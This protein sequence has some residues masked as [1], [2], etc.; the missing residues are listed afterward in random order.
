MDFN[1][2]V[3]FAILPFDSFFCLRCTLSKERKPRYIVAKYD[4]AVC[5]WVYTAFHIHSI[6]ADMGWP[7]KGSLQAGS[8]TWLGVISTIDSMS[9]RAYGFTIVEL[10]IVV[11]VVAILAAISIVAYTGIQNR[12]SDSALQ[13]DLRNIGSKLAEYHAIHGHYPT[14]NA[15]TISGLEPI[16]I[17]EQAYD[18]SVNNLYVCLG[19]NASSGNPMA[20]AVA[21]SRSGKAFS[22][23]STSGVA[24]Y[25]SGYTSSHTTMCSRLGL[26]SG[27]DYALGRNAAESGWRA[28]I[29]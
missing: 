15:T 27:H 26:A 10:L 8:L 11:V 24:E 20:A 25:T 28:W 21:L 5:G 7:V 18:L 2:W 14:A 16:P 1:E 3:L 6:I 4:R 17:T 19:T 12:A 22:Y 23:R 13:S 9:K 29:R